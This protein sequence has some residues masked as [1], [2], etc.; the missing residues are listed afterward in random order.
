M[1]NELSLLLRV[2][3]E[4]LD[5]TLL[6]ERLVGG[7]ADDW[8]RELLAVQPGETA[9]ALCS[10]RL[11]KSTTV[12]VLAAQELAQPDHTV[13]ILSPTLAQ[14]QLLHS[15][16]TRVWEL[17]GLPIPVKRRTL[18]ELHLQN[19]S[20]VL[21]VPVGNDGESARGHGIRQGLLAYDEAA[22]VPDKVFAATMPIAEDRAKTIL[23]TTP[24]G[25]SGKAYQMWTD[26]DQYPDIK[27]IR[28]CS[29]D[30]PR[31]AQTVE[32]ARKNL[33]K[34]EFDVEIGLRW[35]GKGSPFFDSEAITAAF[36]DTPELKLGNLYA[37]LV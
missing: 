16:V 13:I 27:R 20:S 22:W 23:I 9:I 37:G 36:T 31:M 28:A 34:I 35:M 29:L 8:Q 15:K 12:G 25:K 1:S 5:P 19:G 33:S 21:C 11:G 30:I 32:R 4:R 10:R 2:L 14:S 18:T 7:P 17:I 3:S 24:G 6:L 26:H